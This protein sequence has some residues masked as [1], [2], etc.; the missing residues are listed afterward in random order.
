MKANAGAW[1]DHDSVDAREILASA[2]ELYTDVD[3]NAP[4]EEVSAQPNVSEVENEYRREPVGDNP[5][6]AP[7]QRTIIRNA[8]G[9]PRIGDG[10][11]ADDHFVRPKMAGDNVKPRPRPW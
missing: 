7:R 2:P 10:L 8:T 4:S 9:A 6:E 11:P 1:L 3:P 5:P